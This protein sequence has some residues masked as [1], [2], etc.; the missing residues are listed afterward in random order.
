[1][2]EKLWVFIAKFL[3]VSLVLFAF[4][5]WKGEFVYFQIFWQLSGSFYET[6]GLQV[7]LLPLIVP[8]FANL[9]PFLSL[10]IITRGIDLKQ[11]LFRSG[12]GVLIIF[13]WQVFL[14]W[15]MYQMH[16]KT[17]TPTSFALKASLVIYILNYSLPF[18]LWILFARKELAR[19][20]IPH[21]QG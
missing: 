21:R 2:R 20:F 1:M 3:G 16:G 13:G 8:L 10:M 15:A 5:F 11:K 9:L 12:Y 6:F 17:Q 18:I 14:T 19:L 4:W 7:V